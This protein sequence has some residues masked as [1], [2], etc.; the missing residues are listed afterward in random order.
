ML[1]KTLT[2]ELEDDEIFYIG[3]VLGISMNFLR[4]DVIAQKVI[5]KILNAYINTK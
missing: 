2:L 1:T 3:Y 5:L 4:N